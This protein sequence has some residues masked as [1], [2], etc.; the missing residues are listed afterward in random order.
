MF[1]NIQ[2]ILSMKGDTL[3][4][5]LRPEDF[6]FNKE[7]RCHAEYLAKKCPL[8]KA[9]KRGA[10]KNVEVGGYTI[11]HS[12]TFSTLYEIDNNG[13]T[14]NDF[15]YV[16]EAYRKDPEMKKSEYYVTLIEQ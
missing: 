9:L 15:A 16:K 14:F 2:N 13:F 1:E 4:I 8:A 3:H 5:Y 6:D 7:D 11:S 12:K 10:F